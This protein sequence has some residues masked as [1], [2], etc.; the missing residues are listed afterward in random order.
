MKKRW[1]A[2]I[3]GA[4]LVA[5]SMGGFADPPIA[6]VAAPSAAF[7][8]SPLVR[9]VQVPGTVPQYELVPI[10]VRTN[11][12]FVNVYANLT[13]YKSV[14]VIKVKPEVE[15]PGVLLFAFTGPPGKYLVTVELYDPEL[16][17]N[18]EKHVVVISGKVDPDNP[19]DPDNPDPDNPD[20]DNPDPPAPDPDDVKIPEDEFDNLG[21]RVYDWGKVIKDKNYRKLGT[22]L[23]EVYQEAAEGLQPSGDGIQPPRFLKPTDAVNWANAERLKILDT[24]DEQAAW[25]PVASKINADFKPRWETM[26]RAQLVAYYKALAVGV[27]SIAK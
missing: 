1:L 15:E 22:K 10:T 21:Q 4:V 13:L 14:P 3:L 18:K 5:G 16:G 24:T 12:K 9:D 20:P 2:P 23:G 11:Y 19:P 6:G 7:A 26:T 25:E 17:I 27:E 8:Q